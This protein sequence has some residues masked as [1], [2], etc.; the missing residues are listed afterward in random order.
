MNQR[1]FATVIAFLEGN[2][3][4]F[5]ISGKDITMEMWFDCIRDLDYKLVQSALKKHALTSEWPPTIASIRKQAADINGPRIPDHTEAWGEVM[6]AM[7]RH[8]SW[9]HLAALDSMSQHTRRTV[10][11][12]GWDRLCQAENIDVVRGQFLKMYDSLTTRDME[13]ALLPENFRILLQEVQIK[14]LGE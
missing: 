14:R 2:Y 11:A 6:S 12:F 4:K 1:E 5:K 9:N 13:D 7:S 3:D 8:G 10:I